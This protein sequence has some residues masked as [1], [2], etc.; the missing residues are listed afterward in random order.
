MC[1]YVTYIQWHHGRKRNNPANGPRCRDTIDTCDEERGGRS[2][3]RVCVRSTN[4]PTTNPP[5]NEPKRRRFVCGL[6]YAARRLQVSRQVFLGRPIFHLLGGI[7]TP[8]APQEKGCS[9]LGISNFTYQ[10]NCLSDSACFIY[11]YSLEKYVNMPS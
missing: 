6:R 2:V 3:R 4:G 9:Y 5:V 1:A 7:Y 8:Y 11:G 10:E